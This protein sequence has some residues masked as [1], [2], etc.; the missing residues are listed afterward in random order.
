M[1][2][3]PETLAWLFVLLLACQRLSA[4]EVLLVIDRAPTDG[5]VVGRADLTA[6][7]A[8]C[9]TGPIA[10]GGIR[11][12]AVSDGKEIPLVFVPDVDYKTPDRLAGTVV[13]QL[14][15]GSDGRLRLAFGPPSPATSGAPAREGS[16]TGA[17]AQAWDGT[18][19]TPAF[20]VTHDPKRLGGFPQR[21]T[22]LATG[23]TLE[24][25]R[26][27][28]R[29]HHQKLGSFCLADDPE[30]RVERLAIGPPCTVVRTR[31]RFTR[32]GK[33]AASQPE[34]V[35]DWFYF[36]DRPLVFVH[37]VV[38]QREPFAWH[39]RHFL[40]LQFPVA[41]FPEWAMGEPLQQGKFAGAVKGFNAPGW[42]AVLDGRNALGMLAA[43]SI[44]LHDAQGGQGT[45]LQAHGN[46]AW[47][48][49]SETRHETSAWLA[50]GSGEKPLEV[51]RAAAKAMPEG[52]S[53]TATTTEVRARIDAAEKDLTQ[54]A[55]ADRPRAASL[56]AAARQLEAQGRLDEA[57]Q[58]ADGVAP[59][60]W[61][62]LVAGD[63]GAVLERSADGIR[64]VNLSDTAT[65]R[66][67][68]AAKPLPLFRITLRHAET[69]EE[70]PLHADAGWGQIEV[71]D[72]MAWAGA[73][74]RWQQPLDKRFG[75]L[76]VT[77][78]A[79]TGRGPRIQWHLDVDDVPAPWSVWRVVF[80]Q[81]AVADLGPGSRVLFPKAAGEVQQDVWDKAFSFHGTYPSGWTSMQFMAAYDRDCT[82][83]LYV[84][85]HD[86]WG[87]TKDIRAESR[88]AER[89]VV[90]S[91]DH[92]VPD[93]GAPGNRFQLDGPAV[94]QLLRGDW[95]D[96]ASLYRAWV[97][98][99]ARWFPKL[100]AEGRAD[101][102]LWMRELPAW[103]LGG[104]R[105]A[106]CVGAVKA[107]ARF[108]D[109]PCGFHWY[110]WHQIPFDND[111]PHYFPTREGFADG[112]RELQSA[113][114]FV[115]PYI[116]G[117]LWDSRDRGMED[118]EFTKVAR[119]AVSKNEKGEPYLETYGS[120]EADAS[121][122]R[123][124]VMCPTTEL[125][126]TRVRQIVLRL[127][128]EC[129]VRG[130]Y[131]DQVAAAAPTLCFD[132]SHGHPVGGGHW[133]T[134][135]YWRLLEAIRK[136]KPADCMLTTECNGEPYIHCFDGYLTWHWQ[137]DGQVPAFAAVYGGAIQMFGR[138][139]G[140]GPTR[141][142]ALRMRAGQQLVFGEQ[143]GWLGP[144][145][146]N[147]KANAEFLRQV[148]RLRWQ[149]R[150]Y[151]YA[152]EMARPPRL[153]G[154]MPTVRADWQWHGTR[155][156]TTDAVLTG[157]WSLPAEKKL[158]LLF[159]NVSDQPVTARLEYD[160]AACGVAGAS[161]RVTKVTA[162]GPGERFASPS[163]LQREAT[164]PPHSAWAWEVTR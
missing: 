136:A 19:T 127:F 65:G 153:A 18:V 6:A 117:R 162:D 130:V 25:S 98:R 129:G 128:D 147:E 2:R 84:A 50:V 53:I 134:E 88:P 9:K 119:P 11:A 29:L 66:Q 38:A 97:R 158:V 86:P 133:W 115:M 150:R 56:V 24:V 91:F 131:I 137:Y 163:R 42:G 92:P 101:T 152:G 143:I 8:R 70:V 63:L 17:R 23:K 20:A 95:F 77:A 106:D 44:L 41:A 85:V 120:K 51:I 141:D 55:G 110:N 40:E 74:L 27:N 140:G 160:A 43:G 58:A 59:A 156:V 111:Y 72:K 80:P 116:N 36:H 146:V 135:G 7:A 13:V 28:D 107:F 144:G 78:G 4:D 12:V 149:L 108:L 79:H 14:P 159:A 148:V 123:L 71:N 83:G 103:A 62:L 39:E 31:A 164:F 16:P 33:P 124:G 90:L 15:D 161:V 82:T 48:T 64:L 73:A 157:A 122:V 46:A 99:E 22:F 21:I 5:L 57:I 89:A 151:F 155:W 118:F 35:Y 104:G 52:T 102:P 109:V 105:P 113:G 94:W 45:Y 132:A 30:A 114:V 3:L 93:M 87:G 138:S 154:D 49:W 69:K 96:A 47:S 60:N 112:V 68:A 61:T 121:P 54:R 37:A 126:Q 100:S 1:R 125:W 81:V 75:N 76:R 10:P 67:L 26:W 32:G 34:A 145:V 142:L 139:Y